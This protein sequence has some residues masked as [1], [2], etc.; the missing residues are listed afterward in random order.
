MEHHVPFTPPPKP[1]TIA[2]TTIARRN[3]SMAR[4]LRKSSP[5]LIRPPRDKSNAESS[6]ETAEEGDA[7]KLRTHLINL[8]VSATDKEGRA[9]PGLTQGD[10]SIYEDGVL[11][12]ISFFSPERSPFNL[13]LLIDLSGSMK[14]EIELIKETALHFLDVISAQ[15]NVVHVPDKSR[16]RDERHMT[17]EKN[18][19]STHH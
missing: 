17:D 15:D 19:E 6:P 2:A 13:V 5:Q 7:L 4:A 9:I 14:D 18:D 3:S 1:L 11:Q 12:R 16:D 8:N 10:F